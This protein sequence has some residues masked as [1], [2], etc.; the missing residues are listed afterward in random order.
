MRH[1]AVDD[2]S[3]GCQTAAHRRC[4][5]GLRRLA[6]LGLAATFVGQTELATAT[7]TTLPRGDGQEARRKLGAANAQRRREEI[8]WDR[9]HEKPDP[10]VFT[11]QILPLLEGVSLREMKAATGLSVTMCAKVRHGYVPHPRH[12]EALRLLGLAHAESQ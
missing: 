10:E 4:H 11:R 8:E 2:Y 7:S 9:T 12:W 5:Q 1:G 3:H 6:E